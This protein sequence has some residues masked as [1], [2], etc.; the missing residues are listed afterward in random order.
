MVAG[1]VW[2]KWDLHVH[3]PASFQHNFRFSSEEEMKKYNGNIWEKY[4]DELEKLM[5][6]LLLELQTIFP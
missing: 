4:I 1:S 2:R 6:L 5:T 3:T